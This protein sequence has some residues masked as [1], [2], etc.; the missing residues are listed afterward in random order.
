[1]KCIGCGLELEVTH[2]GYGDEVI[3]KECYEKDPAYVVYGKV[4]ME[5]NIQDKEFGEK[6]E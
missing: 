2:P 1:M 4:D 3:C 5:G 6:N